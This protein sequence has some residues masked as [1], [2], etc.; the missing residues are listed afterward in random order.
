MLEYIELLAEQDQGVQAVPT[1]PL[2]CAR[3]NC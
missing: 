3:S 1:V 2:H